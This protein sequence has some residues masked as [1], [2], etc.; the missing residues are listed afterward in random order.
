MEPTNAS[1]RS[2]GTSIE[3]II[4]TA[5]AVIG[6]PRRFFR[7]MPRDGGFVEPLIFVGA[8]NLAA[9]LVALPFWFAGIGPYSGFPGVITA[10]VLPVVMS[11]I[12][13]FLGGAILFFIWRLLGSSQSYETAYRCCAYASVLAPI[14]SIADIL[15]YLGSLALLVWAMFLLVIASEEVHGIERQRARMAFGVIGV[16]LVLMTIGSQRTENR[17]REAT[18]ALNIDGIEDMSPAE[19]GKAV[20]EF[21]KG[22]QGAVGDKPAETNDSPE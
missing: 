4:A 20:G 14:S 11:I 5:K 18:Q 7:A 16:V 19:A 21:M 8:M 17:V 10:V 3:G 12:G 6:D 2:S 22:L 1:A 15:P 9:A 13:S